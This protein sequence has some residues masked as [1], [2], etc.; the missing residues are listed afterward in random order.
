M[1]EL[2]NIKKLNIKFFFIN[3]CKQIT[4][5][6]EGELFKIFIFIKKEIR[7][8]NKQTQNQKNRVTY[9]TNKV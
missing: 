1:V 4:E 2:T 9:R 3:F 6:K 5:L 8:K 7:N